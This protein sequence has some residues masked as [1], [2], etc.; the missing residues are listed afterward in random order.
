[1]TEL[2]GVAEGLVDGIT[3]RDL[4]FSLQYQRDRLRN[5][6]SL[7]NLF[8]SVST[9]Q[10]TQLPISYRSDLNYISQPPAPD[11]DDYEPVVLSSEERMSTIVG[12][13]ALLVTYHSEVFALSQE[14]LTHQGIKTSDKSRTKASLDGQIQLRRRETTQSLNSLWSM[15]S[16]AE[17]SLPLRRFISMVEEHSIIQSMEII[18]S[19]GYKEIH[20]GVVHRFLLLEVS[21]P[22]KPTVWLRLDRRRDYGV[23][24]FAFILSAG[25]TEA[26]DSIFISVDKRQ[27]TIGCTRENVQKFGRT[28]TLDHLKNLLMII[29]EE[30]VVYQLFPGCLW[31]EVP[32][33]KTSLKPSGI[34]LKSG[35]DFFTTSLV[36]RRSASQNRPKSKSHN[37]CAQVER[38]LW[39]NH[40]DFPESAT[41]QSG[42]EAARALDAAAQTFVA[43]RHMDASIVVY[44]RLIMLARELL[45]RMEQASEQEVSYTA[46]IIRPYFHQLGQQLEASGNLLEAIS[47]YREAV[48]LF[49]RGSRSLTHPTPPNPQPARDLFCLGRALLQVDMRNAPEA[50]RLIRRSIT[51]EH[52]LLGASEKY[53]SQS[54]FFP[55]ASMMSYLASVL[56]STHSYEAAA[57]VFD[58]AE[59]IFCRLYE[60]TSKVLKIFRIRRLWNLED[61]GAA[62]LDAKQYE[63]ASLRFQAAIGYRVTWNSFLADDHHTDRLLR[64]H[65]KYGTCLY[66]LHQHE[67]AVRSLQDFLLLLR[68]AT[69]RREI[70]VEYFSLSMV[71]K[72]LGL[73]LVKLDCFG[74][75]SQLR[76]KGSQRE[77]LDDEHMIAQDRWLFAALMAT[78]FKFERT[79]RRPTK[80]LITPFKAIELVY[81]LLQ[82][83]SK[84][85]GSLLPTAEESLYNPSLA[86]T[87]KQCGVTS[88][89][90]RKVVEI[91]QPPKNR[92]L[93][94]QESILHS[95]MAGILDMQDLVEESIFFYAE[96]VMLTRKDYA[97]SRESHGTLGIRLANLGSALFRASTLHIEAFLVLQEAV[98]RLRMLHREDCD[99]SHIL[100]R[101][102]LALMQIG[103]LY[104]RTGFQA[105][106]LSP[107]KEGLDIHQTLPQE[108]VFSRSS[109]VTLTLKEAISPLRSMTHDTDPLGTMEAKQILEQALSY[110]E[111]LSTKSP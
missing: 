59:P 6:R 15:T 49:E 105:L 19:E 16:M 66:H 68:R 13:L 96:S 64:L 28:L 93:D 12:R 103:V 79:G 9:W 76:T 31:M 25:V 26:N 94:N 91:M 86:S 45:R 101:L 3:S 90:F 73:S 58:E 104:Q 106:S 111:F 8:S 69:V 18:S 39:L 55:L 38:N 7:S 65:L 109:E 5:A 50:I 42:L 46:L 61:W 75:A 37:L 67:K 57:L 21:R 20:M 48:T 110:F 99:S 95:T 23:N 10:P 85:I 34:V 2:T 11:A 60:E 80:A 74:I 82:G 62:L 30:I 41:I 70:P 29:E 97:L 14:D 71:I 44:R 53:S 92:R 56:V 4:A 107:L 52:K 63:M 89:F 84:P 35:F 47:I 51:V 24:I 1:M 43:H 72:L 40:Y 98:A 102:S 22:A 100:E 54:D 27:L 78:G 108:H 88:M 87:L 81:L 77:L 33:G 83:P 36:L 32:G 17:V